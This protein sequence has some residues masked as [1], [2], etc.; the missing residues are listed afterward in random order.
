[1]SL[2]AT[3]ASAAGAAGPVAGW[4]KISGPQAPAA[5]Y[6]TI[7]Y[8]VARDQMILFGGH[9]GGGQLGRTWAFDGE[10]WV[11][12]DLALEPPARSHAVMAYDEARQEVVLHGGYKN[13]TTL[14]DTWVF[15]GETWTERT[16]VG[17]PGDSYG[18]ELT[19]DR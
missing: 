17:S 6:S 8:D 3:T 9:G 1:M 15:D 10:S 11:Q 2:L 14:L 5:A 18:G 16:G 4:Q 12:L 19:Y 7:A 13:D